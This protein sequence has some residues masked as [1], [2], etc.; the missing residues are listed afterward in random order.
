MTFQD[1]QRGPGYHKRYGNSACH[2]RDDAESL[3]AKACAKNK[4]CQYRRYGYRNKSPDA[5]AFTIRA[6][7][8]PLEPSATREA[9]KNFERSKHVESRSKAYT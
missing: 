9:Q 8:A 3:M 6:D 7:L 2:V 5:W 4:L 1:R